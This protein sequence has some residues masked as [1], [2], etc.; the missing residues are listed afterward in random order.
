MISRKKMIRKNTTGRGERKERESTDCKRAREKERERMRRVT[1]K[2]VGKKKMIDRENATG[3]QDYESYSKEKEKEN[4]IS[5]RKKER[6]RKK[7]C[8]GGR[9][10]VSYRRWKI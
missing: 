7:K 9:E 5:K 10:S 1:Q 2:M 4:A 8:T 3:L 6:Y